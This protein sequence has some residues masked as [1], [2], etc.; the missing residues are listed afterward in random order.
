ML[1]YFACCLVLLGSLYVLGFA[2]QAFAQDPLP[3]PTLTEAPADTVGAGP[4]FFSWTVPDSV[5]VDDYEWMLEGPQDGSALT[6]GTSITF[7]NL[8]PGDYTFSV[9]VQDD[10]GNVSE[11]TVHTFTIDPTV[12]APVP[13]NDT[14]TL[15][16]DTSATLNV[17]AND[18]GTSDLSLAAV[19]D[20]PNGSAVINGNAVDYAPDPDF[21]GTD[22]F[23]Y[24]V[25][26]EDGQTAQGTV[27]LTIAPVND[28]PVFTSTPVTEV[29]V[30]EPYT[31]AIETNDVE[32]DAETLSAT[33]LPTWLTFIPGKTA[34]AT[35]TGTPNR[36]DI[37]THDVVLVA[38]DGTD[39]N[40]QS[41]TITVIDTNQ[42]PTAA[43]ITSPLSGSD[44]LIEGDPAALLMI[45]WNPGSDPEGQPL[46]YTWQ[47]SLDENFATLLFD[48]NVGI[49][50][51]TAL[52]FGALGTLLTANGVATG[53]TVTLY[54][55]VLTFDTAV[56]VTGPTATMEVTRSTLTDTE[57]ADLPTAFAL[58]GNYPNPFNPVTT[59]R[60]DLPASATVT[61]RLYDML[62]RQVDV[63]NQGSMAAGAQQEIQL[64]LADL[65]SGMYVYRVEA[66][67]V[68]GDLFQ[69][70]GRLTLVK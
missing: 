15:N 33:Q 36:A 7:N 60:F 23:I 24:T 18:T 70:A 68:G 58:N 25:Q 45:A 16:E 55:R 11:W 38:S 47:L 69:G 19:S 9:R 49:N 22:S 6:N 8:P 52:E 17:L 40:A 14:A 20:P 56:E 30:T 1:R 31:Y 44:V 51:E 34:T 66:R 13:T 10:D 57:H 4:V 42:P 32:D 12:D 27:T 61:V 50:L 63:W 5:D 35:L 2:N 48:E 28:A 41:F 46:E 29:N 21:F 39:S 43:V 3:P 67:A 26:D 53:A 54:H 64:E 37:G 62:G 59:V 65:P